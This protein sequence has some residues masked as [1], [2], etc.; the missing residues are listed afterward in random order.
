LG[1]RESRRIV[2]VETL[3]DKGC[4]EGRKSERDIGR[5]AY[6]LDVHQAS[7]IIEHL[8]IDNG[9][10]YG[11]PYGCLVPR[12]LD[13]VLVAGRCLSSERFANGSARNQAH[14]QAMGQAAGTAAAMSVKSGCQPREIDVSALRKT[15]TAQ[16]ALV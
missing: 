4:V 10:S 11:I 14:I 5:G 12:D 6:C 7:G 15:L 9:D 1:V 3:T 16:G 2:G 13:G 8:H